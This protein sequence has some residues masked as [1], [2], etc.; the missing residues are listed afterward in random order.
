MPKSIEE[1]DR[2]GVRVDADALRA[3][4]GDAITPEQKAIVSLVEEGRVLAS[5]LDSEL[6]FSATEVH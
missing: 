1:I 4:Y 2:D 6:Y 3:R 5:L